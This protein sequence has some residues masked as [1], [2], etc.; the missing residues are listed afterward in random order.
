MFRVLRGSAMSKADKEGRE[1]TAEYM[2]KH[3][4]GEP[5]FS[6]THI[7]R[8]LSEEF[9]DDTEEK[10]EAFERRSAMSGTELTFI[11][12]MSRGLNAVGPRLDSKYFKA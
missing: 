11:E 8:Q 3:M 4:S 1:P 10:L 7:V 6:R 2:V 12:S 5:G 9:G